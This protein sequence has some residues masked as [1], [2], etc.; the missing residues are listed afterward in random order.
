MNDIETTDLERF[1][2]L[3][4]GNTRVRGA[5]NRSGKYK[6][7]EVKN[8]GWE[9]AY[10]SHLSG[11]I[12]IGVVPITDDGTCYFG[13]IDIDAHDQSDDEPVDL[14]SLY[15]KVQSLGLPVVVARS[16]SGRGAHIYIFFSKPQNAEKVRRWLFGVAAELRLVHSFEI[17]PKQ[18][19]LVNFD[20][21]ELRMGS[22]INLPYFGETRMGWEGGR[23]ID[24]KHFLTECESK[25]KTDIESLI[26]KDHPEAPPCLQSLMEEGIP[27]G[28]RNNGLYM[29]ALYEHRKGGSDWSDRVKAHNHT[30]LST[31]LG[32]QEVNTI[33]RSVSQGGSKYKC[34]EEPFR[35]FCKS[36]ECV[37]RKYGIPKSDHDEMDLSNADAG[38]GMINNATIAQTNETEA[39]VSFELTLTNAA[40]QE[41]ITKRITSTLTALWTPMSGIRILSTA[42]G[43]Y[44]RA[45][46]K[47]NWD[48]F[49][50]LLFAKAEKIDLPEELTPEGRLKSGINVFFD[51]FISNAENP[52]EEYPMDG[53]AD[54]L[55]FGFNADGHIYFRWLV[56]ERWLIENNYMAKAMDSGAL[57]IMLH[58]IGA[59]PHKKKYVRKRYLNLWSIPQDKLEYVSEATSSEKEEHWRKTIEKMKEDH[60]ETEF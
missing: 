20:T 37:K 60:N 10:T 13:A 40:T 47:K 50:E 41:T 43:M 49:L 2:K 27:P 33:I 48:Q 5:L 7:E 59:I 3:F 53:V 25:V 31:P 23:E 51:R 35:S 42:M 44:V 30:T 26:S 54:E 36:A 58:N 4:R 11:K 39:F 15:N 17:F 6:F 56:I 8:E 55:G 32:A 22:F 46:N 29:L 34:H 14:D 12:G 28:S 57:S 18:A 9:E 21:G 24:L 38:E 19:T 16:K 52:K 45:F 1:R